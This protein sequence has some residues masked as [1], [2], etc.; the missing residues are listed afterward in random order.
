L[1][2]YKQAS[3]FKELRE[4]LESGAVRLLQVNE[5]AS[6][7]ELASLLLDHYKETNEVPS[8]TSLAPLLNIFASYRPTENH[9]TKAAFVSQATTWSKCNANNNQGSPELHSAFAKHYWLRKDYSSA[10]KHY[11]RSDNMEEF[12]KMSV[13][14]CAEGFPGEEDLFFTRPTLMLLAL[15]NLKMANLFFKSYTALL[16]QAQ[17]DVPLHNFCRFL[18]LTLERDALPLFEQLRKKYALSI[19]R[20]PSFEQFLDQIASI[21]FGVKKTSQGGLNGLMGSLFKSLMSPDQP[22]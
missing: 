8:A 6:G 2:R 10:Q 13:E 18:L 1:K 3:K 7:S 16:T 21:F 17:T 11:L 20:D 9:P 15:G 12:A 4:M 14:W 22:M 5:I 19:A